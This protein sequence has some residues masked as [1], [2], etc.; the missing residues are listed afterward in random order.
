MW[1]FGVKYNTQ[2]EIC[3]HFFFK[4]LSIYFESQCWRDR[5]RQKGRKRETSIHWS[6]HQT[7]AMANARPSWSQEPSDLSRSLIWM[8]IG[9]SFAFFPR[10]LVWSC[11]GSVAARTRTCTYMRQNYHMRQLH[12]LCH[13]AGHRISYFM[14]VGRNTSS[15]EASLLKNSSILTVVQKVP[16]HG[17]SYQLC[18]NH[19]G[20]G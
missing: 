1:N 14:R 12:M 6:T 8:A 7:A 19:S 18:P 3:C 4:D 11:A 13:S 5:E 2:V 15:H 20:R 10:P 17:T 9:P 16:A